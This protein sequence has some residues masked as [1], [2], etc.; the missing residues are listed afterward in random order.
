MFADEEITTATIDNT[1]T[2]NLSNADTEAEVP[3]THEEEELMV[4][5]FS[6]F[7]LLSN[8][9]RSVPCSVSLSFFIRSSFTF[10]TC[11]PALQRN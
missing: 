8:Y 3:I 7:F 4:A 6:L 2:T 5:F 10:S 11:G 9:P 1:T